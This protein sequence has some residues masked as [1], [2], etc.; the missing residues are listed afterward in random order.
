MTRL[1]NEPLGYLKKTPFVSKGAARAA[2]AWEVI[3]PLIKK[4]DSTE[5]IVG[6]DFA[7]S[8][9]DLRK[10]GTIDWLVSRP[11]GGSTS[12]SMAER[13]AYHQGHCIRS[14]SGWVWRSRGI[15]GAALVI[16]AVCQLDG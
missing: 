5:Q 9:V 2:A 8:S 11:E 3:H 12:S 13:M 7:K 6:P 16:F 4:A 10:C 1:C 15:F 14:T